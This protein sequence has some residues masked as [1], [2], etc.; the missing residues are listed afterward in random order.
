MTMAGLG[1]CLL[2]YLKYPVEMERLYEAEEPKVGGLP[3]PDRTLQKIKLVGDAAYREAAE[4][5][6]ACVPGIDEHFRAISAV[7]Q[8]RGKLENSWDLRFRVTPRET[9]DRYF[10]IGIAIEPYR[11]A[12]I[13]WVWCRGGRRAED[14]IV[15]ILGQGIKAAT[16]KYESGAVG[17]LEIKIPVPERLEE[18]VASGPLLA[19]VQQAF[20]PFTAQEVKAIA[21]IASNRGEA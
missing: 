5:L 7:Q 12:L 11:T 2:F 8:T 9:T 16:L 20:A 19:Q 13:P 15:R 17:L 4:L 3:D 21:A 1:K 6:E 18:P 14:E 10:E